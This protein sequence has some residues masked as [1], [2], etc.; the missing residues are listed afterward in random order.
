MSTFRKLYGLIR[1]WQDKKHVFTAS[2]KTSFD[3]KLN[4]IEGE[5]DLESENDFIKMTG[6]E[7]FV[8][9]SSDVHEDDIIT[10]EIVH[11]GSET[12]VKTFIPKAY[13]YRSSGHRTFVVDEET[14]S[15]IDLTA[16]LVFRVHYDSQGSVAIK[17]VVTLHYYG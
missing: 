2:S 3:W 6:G 15:T 8:Q 14:I 13:V 12:V 5:G 9:N 17:F 11:L 16:G 10:V 4:K 7:F 1:H